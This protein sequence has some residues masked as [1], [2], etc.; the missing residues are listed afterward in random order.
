MIE[1]NEATAAYAAVADPAFPLD[2]VIT[3]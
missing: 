1:G 2:E 3:P